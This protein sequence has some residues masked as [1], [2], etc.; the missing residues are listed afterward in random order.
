MHGGFHGGWCWSR[1]A[2][3]LAASGHRAYTPTN[4]GLGER[5]HLLSKEIT[6]ETFIEDILNVIDA[7][8]LERIYLVGHS[9]GGRT[10]AGVA[11][12]VPE[13]IARLVFLDANAVVPGRSA[14]DGLSPAVRDERLDAARERNG[15]LAFA[16]PPAESFGVTI[17]DDAA[18]LTRRMTPHPVSSYAT[19][20]R[21]DHPVGNGLPCTYIR[22]TQP[23][24]PGVDAG[25]AYAKSRPD[26]QYLE[27]ATGHDAMV[28]APE[29]LTDLLLDL[30]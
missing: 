4:T 30:G 13:R 24:Y 17:A 5:K 7:E 2:D 10:V 23:F 27:I 9:F 25:G 15:G 1:V 14:M 21:L 22:C 16:V 20:I 26:W 28:T 19:P 8:E 12:R 6:L 11:D 3:R 29:A 18:W